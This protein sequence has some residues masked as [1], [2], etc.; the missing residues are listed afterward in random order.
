MKRNLAVAAFIVLF[1]ALLIYSGVQNI[2][3]RKDEAARVQQQITLTPDA[4][5]GSSPTP[6]DDDTPAD[7]RGKKATGFKLTALD[8]SKVSLDQFKGKAVLINFWATWCA[9]CKVEMPWFE[10]FNKKYSAQ[11]LQIVGIVED[12]APKEAVQNIVQKT[13]VTYP[14]LHGDHKVDGAYGGVDYLPTSYW[15][16]R[17]GTIVAQSYGLGSK[18][19][20]EANVKKIVAQ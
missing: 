10:E 11:G 3:R 8:G 2:H 9:P 19:E 20:M 18:D 5:T 15:V 7:L 16:D 14:I 4:K 13:G 12:D 1:L 6:S 17:T